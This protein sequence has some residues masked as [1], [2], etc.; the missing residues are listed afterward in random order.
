[1]IKQLWEIYKGNK[2]TLVDPYCFLN[3]Y[4]YYYLFGKLVNPATCGDVDDQDGD[5]DDEDRDDQSLVYGDV[6]GGDVNQQS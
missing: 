1:M 5:V 2:Y 3:L 6:S 4:L